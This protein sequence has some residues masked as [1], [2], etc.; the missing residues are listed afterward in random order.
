M[1]PEIQGD[2]ETTSR[3]MDAMRDLGFDR[4]AA[5][6]AS[7]WDWRAE[8]GSYAF[9]EKCCVAL[10]DVGSVRGLR[11]AINLMRKLGHE[12]ERQVANFYLG[13]LNAQ[14]GAP[15]QAIEWLTRFVKAPDKH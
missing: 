7:Q 6:L 8:G 15:E 1:L 4:G 2:L 11:Q 5:A 14:Q 10:F 9:A 12:R 13:C 3:L